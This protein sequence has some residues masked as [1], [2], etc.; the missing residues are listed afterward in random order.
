MSIV[1]RGDLS[2]RDHGGLRR[3]GANRLADQHDME[4]VAIAALFS[5]LFGAL[6][7]LFSRCETDGSN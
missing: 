3:T 1:T 5:V 2:P 7:V 6:G 4:F